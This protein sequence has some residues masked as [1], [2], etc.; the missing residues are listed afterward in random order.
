MS[1]LSREV[2]RRLQTLVRLHTAFWLNL[3]EVFA[4]TGRDAGSALGFTLGVVRSLIR[5][6]RPAVIILQLASDAQDLG[7]PYPVALANFGIAAEQIEVDVPVAGA[8]LPMLDFGGRAAG[9]G[10]LAQLSSGVL[11]V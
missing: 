1:T 3:H 4:D 2:P 8:T 7:V 5:P 6:E 9:G 10:L 11:R